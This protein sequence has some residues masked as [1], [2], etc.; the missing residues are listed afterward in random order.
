VR[1][2]ASLLL[3]CLPACAA[4]ERS[5]A[6]RADSAGIEIVTN[7]G[8]DH[9]LDW[10][11]LTI[12]TLLD[13]EADTALQGDA[14]TLSL[15]VDGQGRLVFADGGFNDRRVFRQGDDGTLYQVGRRGG[16]PGEYEMV[17]TVSASPTGELLILDYAKRSFVR[18]SA[19]DSI[20]PLLPF[21]AF[22]PGWSHVG[23]FAGGGI[24][25]VSEEYSETL[26]VKQVSLL[27]ATDTIPLV[28]QREAGGTF[29]RFES[30]N[31]GMAGRPIFD[32]EPVWAGND[33]LVAV[34]ATDRYQV[35]IWR[36][37]RHIRSI[38]RDLAPRAATEAL[39]GRE[40]GE[41]RKISIGGGPPC[42]IPAKEII[43]QQGLAPTIPS[44]RRLT[45]ARDGTLW[46]ERYTVNGEPLQ[47][48]IFDPTGNYL[49]TLTGDTPWPQAW[50]PNGE[51]VAVAANEDSL[52]VVIRYGV[53]GATRQ[54]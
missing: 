21:A 19:S 29:S 37:G 14:G 34:A 28:E 8:A 4:P 10:S 22:G 35:E 18:F 7:T 47:R 36:G 54:E 52:P 50:M 48:D 49:G 25:G 51:Y 46:V 32:P 41:G 2:T 53:G 31:V 17:G 43:A 11:I 24:V 33:D 42:L 30:C 12:D 3:L 38:R 23:A 15:A 16:G 39:A 26:T 6:V 45:M 1:S 27:T 40:L 5:E 20:L 13:P 44:F 9:A